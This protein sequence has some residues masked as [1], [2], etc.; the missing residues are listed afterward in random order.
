MLVTKENNLSSILTIVL[1]LL[2]GMMMC[3]CNAEMLGTL[4]YVLVG[5]FSLIGVIQI[6]M[7]FVEREYARNTYVSLIIG[8]IFLWLALFIYVYYWI[9]DFIITAVFSLYAFMMF[10]SFAIKYFVGDGSKESI[11]TKKKTKEVKH[12]E[13]RYLVI[14][15]L[16]LV[17]GVVLM[18]RPKFDVYVYFKISGA[19]VI[20]VS[21]MLMFEFLASF[22][23]KDK[24]EE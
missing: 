19:Y 15:I 16:S 12:R 8:M 17:L 21:I 6:I 9:I 22:R 13:T 4:N 10:V 24:V 11:V 2:L 5:I 18:V 23:K 7:F 14:A 20:A 1:S 3:V